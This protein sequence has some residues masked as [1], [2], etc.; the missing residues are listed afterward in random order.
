[1]TLDSLARK[2]KAQLPRTLASQQTVVE[3]LHILKKDL[4]REQG[5]LA[6]EQWLRETSHQHGGGQKENPIP[7]VRQ[8]VSIES[9]EAEFGKIAGHHLSS[10]KKGL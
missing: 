6:K 2:Y 5:N 8:E 9:L 3:D 10:G 1:M 4:G 7:R